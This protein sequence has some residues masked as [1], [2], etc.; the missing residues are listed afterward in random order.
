MR[1]VSKVSM[2]GPCMHGA[3]LPAI[4][5]TRTALHAF[6]TCT[7]CCTIL[8]WWCFRLIGYW[9]SQQGVVSAGGWRL[10]ICVWVLVGVY[11]SSHVSY[12]P[13]PF[14]WHVCR[15]KRCVH[16][17]VMWVLEVQK[18]KCKGYQVNL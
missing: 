12:D 15:K 3:P 2:S 18:V 9:Q 11:S 5:A 16:H 7:I 6:S 14:N 4:G 8:L 17:K 13:W 10:Q 1:A